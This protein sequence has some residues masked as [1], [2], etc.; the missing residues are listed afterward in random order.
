MTETIPGEDTLIDLSSD[1]L[2]T[3]TEAMWQ[4][5]RSAKLGMA[6][7]G[8]DSSVNTLEKMA[9]QITGKEAA[10]FV[11]T[12]SLANLLALL[13]HANR[14]EQVILEEHTHNLRCEEWG[15]GAICGLLPRPIKGRNGALDPIDVEQ[16]ITMRHY[17][18]LPPS[19]LVVLENAF[20]AAGGTVITP[21]QTEAVCEVAHR[22]G[23]P[24]HLDGSRIFNAAV[25]LGVDVRA[26]VETVDS[27]AFS[28]NKG[29]SA[30]VGAM[31]CG[32]RQFIEKARRHRRVLGAGSIHKSGIAAAAGIVALNTMIDRLAEDNRRARMLA[33]GLA[34]VEGVQIDLECVQTSTV[35]VDVT[36]SGCSGAAFQAELEK[37]G[38]RT[39]LRSSHVIRL[40]T[41]R[42]I[43]DEEVKAVVEAFRQVA[44]AMAEHT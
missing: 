40:I 34:Q 23:V 4:A 31:L 24:V 41:Y 6:S 13:T 16:A 3:P 15:I 38:V 19:G 8:T 18:H 30:P 44:A 36:P 2:T 27:V 33:E 10:L 1:V 5:M 28:L 12:G 20:D 22:Y 26:L 32:S 7:A 37:L 43:G 42:H 39:N 17:S 21:A 14:G 9:A 25:A 29:L 35:M 11:V